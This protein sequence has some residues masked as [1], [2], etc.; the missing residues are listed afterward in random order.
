MTERE[1]FSAVVSSGPLLR[2]DATVVLAGDD[3]IPRINTAAGLMAQNGAP[4]VLV[5]GGLDDPPHIHGAHR[6]AG[7]LMAL[8][9]APGCIMTEETST[10]TYEQAQNVIG[11][12]VEKGWRRLLLVASSYH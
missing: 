8:G 11:I 5:S 1:Q 2:A 7:A 10:N 6:L 3:A 12:A 9:V 4:L